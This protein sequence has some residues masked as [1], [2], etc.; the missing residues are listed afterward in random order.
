[1]I[2]LAWFPREQVF[3]SHR[4]NIV[5]TRTLTH[6]HARTH[7]RD[8]GTY[9]QNLSIYHIRE[10]ARSQQQQRVHHTHFFVRGQL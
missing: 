10:E 7:A 9:A 1:M 2:L 8:F 6:A 4:T 3:L 5:R